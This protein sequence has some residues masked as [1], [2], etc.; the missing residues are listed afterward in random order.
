MS[1]SLRERAEQLSV[2]RT[3]QALDRHG[4]AARAPDAA[5]LMLRRNVPAASAESDG[6]ESGGWELS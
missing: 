5:C 2:P 4:R 6:F 1:P 3:L